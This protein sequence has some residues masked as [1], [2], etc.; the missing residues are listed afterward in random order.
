MKL[1]AANIR[2]VLD[3]SGPMTRQE[4]AQFFP[5]TTSRR[6]AGWI[7]ALRMPTKQIYIKEWTLEGMG[8]RYPRPIYALGNR[9]DAKKPQPVTQ[10]ARMKEFRRRMKVPNIPNSVFAWGQM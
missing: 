1:S 3:I 7:A 2:S 8:R 5:G 4:I 6:M 10:S 9:R